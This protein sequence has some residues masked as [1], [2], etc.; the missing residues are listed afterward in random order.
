M[1]LKTRNR[2]S[3]VIIITRGGNM[4]NGKGSMEPPDEWA[5]LKFKK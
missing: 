5:M 3:V 2:T 4:M 1:V